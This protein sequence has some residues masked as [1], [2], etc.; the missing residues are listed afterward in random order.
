MTLRALSDLAIDQN[1]A[2]AASRLVDHMRATGHNYNQILAF[3]RVSRP[4]VT[5]AQWEDL[6]Q[7][8]DSLESDS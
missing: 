2:R 8:A 4:D 1:D 3:V 5:D 7:A 6:M